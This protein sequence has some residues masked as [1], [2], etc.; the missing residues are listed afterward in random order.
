VSRAD[1]YILSI[2]PGLSTGIALIKYN[3]SSPGTFVQG[4][5][6]LGGAFALN[7]W[8][9]NFS[10]SWVYDDGEPVNDRIEI[11]AEKFTARNTRGFSYRTEALEPLRCEG[12]L[13][14]HH[15]LPDYP[16]EHW[17]DPNQQYIFGGKD[18][19]SK[20]KAQ[21][22]WLKENGF[23][24]TGKDLGTPDADDYRSAAAHAISYLM[25]KKHHKPTFDL[26]VGGQ[27]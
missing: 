10:V 12:V 9:R 24:L 2:D 1:H 25:K 5:Q 13:L 11:I 14:A 16:D 23:Y 4:W 26:V 19:A 6:I 22:A 3:T 18:K 8:L 21:H 20:K 27:K 17:R 15:V 7:S